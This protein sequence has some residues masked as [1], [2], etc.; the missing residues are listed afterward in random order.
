M[1]HWILLC[2]LVTSSTAIADELPAKV[3]DLSDW[4]LTLPEDTDRPGKP[5]EIKQT[6]LETFSDPRYFFAAPT[7]GVVFRA[8]CG[9]ATTK[10]SS[11]PRCELR[12]MADAKNR[13]GWDTGGETVHTMTMKV[14]I[15]KTPPVKQHVVCAQIH[16]ADDDLMMIRL[17]GTKLFI[18]RND[19]GDVMLDR[20]YKL[21]SPIEL[22]IQAADGHVKVWHDGDLKMDWKVSRKGCYFKAGCYT[23]SNTQ[24]GDDADS[25]AEVVIYD[26]NVRG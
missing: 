8:H 14:A 7:G 10:G 11:F 16:D 1:R 24:R 18:E 23:Q 6:E 20:K 17:E 15:A 9:G 3:L 19:V 5:D 26:L 22:K 2:L 4:M 21:G 12:E 25:Y 13:A